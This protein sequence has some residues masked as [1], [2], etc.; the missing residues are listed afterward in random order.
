MAT[1]ISAYDG[2]VCYGRCDAKCYDAI[3]VSADECDCVCGGANHG[4]GLGQ[5]LANT[6]ALAPDWLKRERQ[7]RRSRRLK[8]EMPLIS[9]PDLFQ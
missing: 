1:L 5:A 4:V 2:G 3:G 8:F 9:Q 7:H 6:I